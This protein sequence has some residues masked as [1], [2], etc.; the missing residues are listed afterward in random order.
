M[1][2]DSTLDIPQGGSGKTFFTHFC[3][4]RKTLKGRHKV[5][6]SDFDMFEKAISFLTSRGMSSQMFRSKFQNFAKWTIVKNT[7]PL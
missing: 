1:T 5:Q 2:H 6:V 4:S 7:Y 3:G